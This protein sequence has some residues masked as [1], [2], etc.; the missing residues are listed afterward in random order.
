MYYIIKEVKIPKIYVNYA[1]NMLIVSSSYCAQFASF[2]SP[3]IIY[4]YI[5]YGR[6]IEDQ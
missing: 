6:G 2:S 4:C 3:W 5:V 1:K